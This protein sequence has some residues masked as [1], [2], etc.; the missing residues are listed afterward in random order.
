MGQKDRRHEFSNSHLKL[1]VSD[2]FS[3]PTAHTSASNVTY[4]NEVLLRPLQNADMSQPQC[5]AALEHKT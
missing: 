2:Y 5:T 3:P 1:R 4:R